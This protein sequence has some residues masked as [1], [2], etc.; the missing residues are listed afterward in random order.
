[1]AGKMI[2]KQSAVRNNGKGYTLVEMIVVLVVLSILAASG[3]VLSIQTSDEANK[4]LGI[5]RN[6]ELLECCR[7][8]GTDGG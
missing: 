2:F 4:V 6:H 7:S 8:N 5:G 1:M 3:D